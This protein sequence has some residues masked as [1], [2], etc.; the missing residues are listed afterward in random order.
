MSRILFHGIHHAQKPA[1]SLFSM[2][3]HLLAS[4]GCPSS[5]SA[6]L[7]SGAGSGG[8][9]PW[10][11][12]HTPPDHA[13]VSKVSTVFMTTELFCHKCNNIVPLAY[14]ALTGFT[15]GRIVSL[16]CPHFTS[17]LRMYPTPVVTC[18]RCIG[19]QCIHGNNQRFVFEKGVLQYLGL[20]YIVVRRSRL[21][22]F[23]S[24]LQPIDLLRQ[25]MPTSV[26]IRSRSRLPIIPVVHMLVYSWL[27]GQR[28]YLLSRALCHS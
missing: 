9:V 4:I 3:L 15:F 13:W 26:V 6:E 2:N 28:I 25:G 17:R 22:Y 18:C 16:P 23:V 5:C 19:Y 11:V 24:Y 14:W 12:N 27:F 1:E 21:T 7:C 10:P 8:L 20:R